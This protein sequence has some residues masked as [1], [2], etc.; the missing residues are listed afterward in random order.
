MARSSGKPRTVAVDVDGV[1]KKQPWRPT[2]PWYVGAVCGPIAVLLACWLVLGALAAVGWLTSPHA[3][4]GGALNLATRMLLLANGAPVQ[5]AAVEVGIVPLG[6]SLLLIVLGVPI[7]SYAARQAGGQAAD[8][9]D[10]GRIWVDGEAITLRVGGCFAGVYAAGVALLAALAGSLSL[11]ALLGA[12]AIGVVTGLWGAARGVGYDPTTT[13]PSWLRSVPRA[14]GAAVLTMLAGGAALLVV[15]LWVSRDQVTAIGEQLDGGAA[16]VFLLTALHLA[17]LP[18][19]VLACVSWILGAGITV[20]DGSL[21][22]MA[23][24]DVGLLPAIPILGAVPGP[25]FGSTGN[26]WWLAVGL[27][28]GGLA[29]AVVT[30]ARPRARF[31]ETALVGGLSGVLAGAL[32]VVVC[33][34]GSG[35]LGSQRL[36]GIGARLDALAVFAPTILGLSGMLAGLVLGLLRRPPRD[37]VVGLDG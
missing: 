16:S 10:T 3:S 25:D 37:E 30:L 13:W 18:N 27:L 33:A 12:V 26:F 29:G 35:S 15:A 2:W 8:P 14:M 36:A 22:T 4:L 28:G 11:R 20:G 32:V 34:L 24:S 1:Q 5:I 9:D 6:I 19:F 7:A 21:I 23:T 17:Y 31:D